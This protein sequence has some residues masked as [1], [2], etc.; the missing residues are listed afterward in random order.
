MDLCPRWI[1]TG[2][3]EQIWIFTLS[4]SGSFMYKHTRLSMTWPWLISCRFLFYKSLA[5]IPNLQHLP[6]HGMLFHIFVT[7]LFPQNAA[8]THQANTYCVF[9]VSPA[10]P[11]LGNLFC[12]P[13]ISHR[14]LWDASTLDLSVVPITLCWLTRYLHFWF[15]LR[16][17]KLF[18]GQNCIAHFWISS[19]QRCLTQGMDS[20]NSS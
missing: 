7:L 4:F 2:L 6:K 1:W 8:I 9:R 15:S 19:S 14:H 20:L 10:S 5:T 3:R 13:F 16:N 12:L 17:Y 11:V 18:V